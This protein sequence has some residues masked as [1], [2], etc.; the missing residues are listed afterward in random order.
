[1]AGA[2]GTAAGDITGSD[3]FRGLDQS[4]GAGTAGTAALDGDG[5]DPLPT[6]DL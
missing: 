1:M 4:A 5:T 2:T 3:L 6:L